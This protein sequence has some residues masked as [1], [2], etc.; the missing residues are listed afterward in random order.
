LVAVRLARPLQ[1]M[2]TT[3]ILIVGSGPVGL[4]LAYELRTADI[5][6]LVIDSLPGRDR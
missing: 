1:K 5:D 2:L 3:T 4:W 6:V